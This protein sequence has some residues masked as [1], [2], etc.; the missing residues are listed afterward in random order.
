LK[1]L[2][3][4]TVFYNHSEEDVRRLLQCVSALSAP[5]G[6]RI[7][8]RT[9]NCGNLP[10]LFPTEFPIKD[11]THV[12]FGENLGF[13]RAQNRLFFSEPSDR[14]W[15]LNPDTAF[16][17]DTI[18]RLFDFADSRA[19][20]GIIEP[21]LLPI[22]HPKWVDFRTFET[23]WCS[24]CAP[25]IDSALFAMVGG[26]DESFFLYSED[27]DLSWRIRAA[28][29]KLY[30]CPSANV[31]HSRLGPA[32]DA[33]A[34]WSKASELQLLR[35][36]GRRAHYVARLG[37]HALS[38]ELEQIREDMREGPSASEVERA[39]ASWSG[40]LNAALRWRPTALSAREP[41]GGPFHAASVEAAIC[42][43]AAGASPITVSSQEIARQLPFGAAVQE[44]GSGEL[45]TPRGLPVD[46]VASVFV[47]PV[48]DGYL[49][50]SM[51]PDVEADAYR[52]VE[53]D[54]IPEPIEDPESWKVILRAI[55]GW[56]RLK[57]KV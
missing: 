42:A 35:K 49:T 37:D 15:M 19:G 27:V 11:H 57:G 13:G 32:S 44:G 22:E 1:T 34:R 24:G 26:F 33:E 23:G 30:C 48:G 10:V 36:Y 16:A 21:R 12:D 17:R 55:R 51:Q 47:L 38:G 46:R 3:V 43:W 31:Y 54:K 39:A 5:P 6:W 52:I 2:A 45:L 9:G 25:L 50:S 4:Q 7:S 29:G 56:L 20:W 41:G 18:S 28:G 40:R 8:F 53:T 14:V